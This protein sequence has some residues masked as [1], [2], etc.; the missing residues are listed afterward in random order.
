MPEPAPPAGGRT[1]DRHGLQRRAVLLAIIGLLVP[2]AILAELGRRG[3]EDTSRRLAKER[4]TLARSVAVAVE[5]TVS[6]P[7]F[8]GSGLRE[9]RAGLVLRTFRDDHTLAVELLDADGRV[10]AASAAVPEAPDDVTATAAVAS[11]AWR[12]RVRQ[13]RRDAFAEEIALKGWFAFLTPLFLVVVGLFAWGAARSVRRPLGA[14]TDSADRLAAGDLSQPVPLPPEDDGRDDETGRLARA[15]ETMRVA[16]ATSMDEV[17]QA[18]ATLERRVAART[19][20]LQKLYAE[21][22]D[23]DARRAELVRKLLSA[24]EDERRRIARELHDETCQT[25]AAL[26]VGLDT[27]SRAASPVEASVRLED[28]RALASRTLDGLHRVIFDLRPSVLDDL[29]LV[30]AVRWWVARHL[31]PAGIAVRLEIED[32]EDR[33]PPTVEIPVFRAIQEALTNA[34]RHSGAKTVLIQMSHEGGTL[35][36]DVEDDGRGFT[37]ADVAT[38]SETGQG[39]GLLGMRER[40]EILGGTLKLDSSPGA[41]THVAFTVPVPREEPARAAH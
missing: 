4:E 23:R 25:V 36:V 20:E 16:L 29:G 39:L 15:F 10:F 17:T 19:A 24:Q 31:T 38:P 11:T 37:P 2:A 33:L 40:I 8:K 13:P 27:V 30:S 28:A 14:L 21:L 9:A 26:A 22:K 34:V 6:D 32:L 18:N 12:V 5:M 3:F 35:S 7:D 41:G 1:W